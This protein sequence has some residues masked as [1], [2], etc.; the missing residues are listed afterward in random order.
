[1][2]HVCTDVLY[3]VLRIRLFCAPHTQTHSHFAGPFD[4][5][6]QSCY[7]LCLHSWRY[8]EYMIDGKTFD[9]NAFGINSD[10]NVLSWNLSESAWSIFFRLWIDEDAHIH[11]H[12]LH[13]IWI[14]CESVCQNT[15]DNKKK[16]NRN[17]RKRQRKH[18]INVKWKL[19]RAFA[20]ANERHKRRASTYIHT[21]TCTFTQSHT[22]AH[23]WTKRANSCGNE[24][25][26]RAPSCVNVVC[27]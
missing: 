13:K 6:L 22:H 18:I 20:L 9:F 21:E 3:F 7:F 17:H 23:E 25:R 19:S 1:M 11:S 15:S 26:A 10:E 14:K 27:L 8:D 24:K 12:A 2:C 16:T 4:C 5:F